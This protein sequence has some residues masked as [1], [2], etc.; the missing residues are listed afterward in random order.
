LSVA[1]IGM[2]SFSGVWLSVLV[3]PWFIN[4]MALPASEADAESWSR[5]ASG[6]KVTRQLPAGAFEFICGSE[7]GIGPYQMCSLF[8]PVLEFENQEAAVAAAEA[9]LDALFDE[10]LNPAHEKAAQQAEAASVPAKAGGA[11]L[12]R[13]DLMFGGLS[14]KEGRT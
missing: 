10:S 1:A 6:T 7:D 12:S 4:V 11:Q 14:S 9:A 13:R 5:L 8:S 2:R 3:T